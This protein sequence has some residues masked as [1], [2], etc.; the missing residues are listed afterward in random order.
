MQLFLKTCRLQHI[1]QCRHSEQE[2]VSRFTTRFFPPII[3]RP[4]EGFP[5]TL[6]T[7]SMRLCLP[8]DDCMLT[9]FHIFQGNRSPEC[10]RRRQERQ[11]KQSNCLAC[12]NQ[13]SMAFATLSTDSVYNERKHP[14]KAGKE[15]Q[16]TAPKKYPMI[17]CNVSKDKSP[18]IQY[19]FAK[20]PCFVFFPFLPHPA[21]KTSGANR[22]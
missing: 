2:N 1:L 13:F 18:S 11:Q 14:G 9:H 5:A 22:P 3:Y 10:A 4:R 15:K 19:Y 20:Y 21:R 6:H 12:V 17:L 8:P 16:K 7:H